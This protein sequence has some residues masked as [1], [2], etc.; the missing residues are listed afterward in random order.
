M[1]LLIVLPWFGRGSR[2]HFFNGPSG[3]FGSAPG[4]DP[5]RNSFRPSVNVRLAP[6]PRFA[7]SLARKPSTII[8]VPGGREFLLKPNLNREFGLPP[9][10]IQLATL[11]SGSFTSR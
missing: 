5:P 9:S 6:T 1:E 3:R 8:S 4:A 11:P 10:I 2:I 7:P